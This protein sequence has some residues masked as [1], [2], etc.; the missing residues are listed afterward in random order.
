MYW[1]H[2][3]FVS[4]TG[5]FT[6]SMAD[7]P[8]DSIGMN[9]LLQQLQRADQ[10][11]QHQSGDFQGYGSFE[12]VIRDLAG[13]TIQQDDIEELAVILLENFGAPSE[14][15]LEPLALSSFVRQFY[16]Q[17]RSAPGLASQT[18]GYDVSKVQTSAGAMDLKPNVFLRSRARVRPK[19]VQNSPGQPGAFTGADGGAATGILGA[20]S[21]QY[22]ITEVNDFGESSP[23]N[24]TAAVV[25]AADNSSV[26]LTMPT[27]QANTK[28]FKV[29]RSAAGG[30]VN[31]CEFIGN[32]RVGMSAY[33]DAGYKNPGLGEA[34]MLDMN[35]ECMRFKQLA[36]LS[37]LNF[38][39]VTTA[40]EFGIVLYGALF[41]YTPRFCGAWRNIGK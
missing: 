24:I 39:I 38:A 9:G 17:F 13:N 16:P 34:Y 11:A 6:G 22:Q 40:L 41:V 32:Y 35:A 7:I 3:H 29:Y 10:D 23:R 5:T 30:A 12:S 25:V 31:T 14:I 37:K 19:G 21:Y 2:A 36:P 26:V 33:V 8:S 27:P 28:Y 20:G 4:N 18:V 15:H 1:G